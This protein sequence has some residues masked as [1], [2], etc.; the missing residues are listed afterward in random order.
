M[1]FFRSSHQHIDSINIQ[2]LYI[3][4]L[5]NKKP[6]DFKMAELRCNHRCSYALHIR[7]IYWSSGRANEVLHHVKM[8]VPHSM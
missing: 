1:A 4:S 3:S 2:G 7:S 8:P 5:A 6:K